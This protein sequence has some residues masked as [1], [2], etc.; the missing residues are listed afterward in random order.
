MKDKKQLIENFASLSFLQ[1][2]NMLIPLF[3]TPYLVRVLGVENFGLITFAVSIS[4]Y[5][6]IITNFG[7]DISIPRKIANNRDNFNKVSELFFTVITIKIILMFISFLFLAL[8]IFSIDRLNENYIIYF[9]SFGVVLGNVLFP[10]WFFQGMEKMKYISSINII[11]RSFFTLMI[12]VLVNDA[13]DIIYVPL[14]NSIGHI[15]AGIYSLILIY[16]KFPIIFKFP[17][18]SNLLNEL[19]DSFQV[20]ISRISNKGS[21]FFAITIIGLSF[22]N[23]ILGLYTIVEKLYYAFLSVAGVVSQTIYPYMCRTRNLVFFKKIL[24][25]VISTS[26][27]VLFPILYYRELI[28]SFIFDI[29]DTIL[30][31]FFLI[32]FIGAFFGTI[33]ILIGYPLLGAFGYMNYANKSLIYSSI[34]Y[35]ILISFFCLILKNIYLAV[36]S[37]AIYQIIAMFFRLFYIKKTG[38]LKDV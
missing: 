20:F 35:V 33:S 23:Y 28:L 34:I 10:V 5:F 2:F 25:I 17:A 12:F 29:N 7:F 11:T 24:I 22:G 27:I 9:L 21:R 18:K 6:H 8:L 38:I 19:K 31:L 15:V 26:F 4:M 32:I 16:R 1:I 13:D 36:L 30:S 37:L 3:T 14:L